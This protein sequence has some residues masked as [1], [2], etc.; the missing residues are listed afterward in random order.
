LGVADRISFPGPI[1]KAEVPARLN[2]GDVFLN[3]A[4]V[5]N[6]PV[7]L[8][9]AMA[10][11]LCVVSARVGGIPYLVDD[12]SDALL[13]QPDNPRRMAQAVRRIYHEPKLA[14]RLSCNG[15]RKAER[16]DW[17]VIFSAWEGVLTAAANE[18]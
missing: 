11:G 17:P 18:R 1:T 16:F 13:A 5:D 10:C 9:E 4:R 15:R 7:S 3:T 2:Q 8:L 6:T 12:G 14:E